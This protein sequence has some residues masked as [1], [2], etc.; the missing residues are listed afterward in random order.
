MSRAPKAFVLVHGGQ[1]TS[2]CWDLLRPH[3]DLDAIA[4]D[5]PGRPGAT[6]H[7]EAPRIADFVTAITEGIDSASGPVVLVGHSASGPAVAIAAGQRSEQVSRVIFIASLFPEPGTD[8]LESMPRPLRVLIQRM[9]QQPRTVNLLGDRG[10]R[11]RIARYLLCND[12]DEATTQLALDGLVPETT[13]AREPFRYPEAFWTLPRAYIALARDR[14]VRPKQVRTVI[15]RL[16]PVD[17]LHLD[18][19]H[20]AMLSQPG[21]LATLLNQRAVQA[22]RH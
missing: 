3:L 14:V 10:L 11:A 9:S 13:V 20:N 12:M 6:H 8:G 7:P 21:Q 17:V 19:G 22:L 16:Q 18:A 5:L 2:R 1:H 15:A 4:V